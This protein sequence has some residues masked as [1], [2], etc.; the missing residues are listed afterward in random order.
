MSVIAELIKECIYHID[1]IFHFE[2]T[3]KNDSRHMF[4]P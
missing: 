1:D 2:Q 4:I 3:E